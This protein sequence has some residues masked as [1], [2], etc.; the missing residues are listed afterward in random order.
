MKVVPGGRGVTWCRFVVVLKTGKLDGGIGV[1]GR[2]AYRTW[3]Q[4]LLD[5][6]MSNGREVFVRVSMR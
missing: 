1:G 4:L 5:N 2:G 3:C 6:S